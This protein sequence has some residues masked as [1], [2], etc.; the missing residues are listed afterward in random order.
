MT[1]SKAKEV[2]SMLKFSVLERVSP[3]LRAHLV[4]NKAVEFSVEQFQQVGVDFRMPIDVRSASIPN[5]SVLIIIG[6]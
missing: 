6:T 4:Q 1:S 2:E 3:L 5:R